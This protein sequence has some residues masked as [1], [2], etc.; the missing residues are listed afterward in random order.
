MPNRAPLS[1][2]RFLGAAGVLG[3]PGTAR[4]AGNDVL[5]IGWQRLGSYPGT[6]AAGKRVTAILAGSSR[7][8][9]C[10]YSSVSEPESQLLTRARS[11]S[12][13]RWSQWRLSPAAL[14]ASVSDMVKPWAV[15]G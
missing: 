13:S 2:R 12:G 6:D 11:R 15:P 8:E 1:R 10:A 5:P 9:A 4:A 7:P 14:K 3:G